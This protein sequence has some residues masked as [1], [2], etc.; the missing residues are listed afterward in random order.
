MAIADKIRM[1]IVK[2]FQFGLSCSVRCHPAGLIRTWPSVFVPSSQFHSPQ[3]LNLILLVLLHLSMGQLQRLRPLPGYCLWSLL[4]VRLLR[5]LAA[6]L[7][8]T[9]RPTVSSSTTYSTLQLM[10][11]TLCLP[12]KKAWLRCFVVVLF[13]TWYQD[14]SVYIQFRFVRIDYYQCFTF[15]YILQSISHA[16]GYDI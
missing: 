7:L 3:L 6:L 11:V 9:S 13:A 14:I 8:I 5:L 12:L 16:D 10:V 15:L 2:Q 1:S 4:K